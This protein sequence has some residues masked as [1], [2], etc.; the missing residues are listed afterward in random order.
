MAL[1]LSSYFYCWN[2]EA[3]YTYVDVYSMELSYY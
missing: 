2:N 1:M 3:Y